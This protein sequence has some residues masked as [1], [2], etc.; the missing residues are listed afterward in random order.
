MT[1]ALVLAEFVFLC[2]PCGF[3]WHGSLWY[4]GL[5]R[6]GR[7]LP[8]FA[9]DGAADGDAPAPSAP[10]RAESV[11]LAPAPVPVTVFAPAEAEI[12]LP[13][14]TPAA[15]AP[16]DVGVLL[17]PG[18]GL[19]LDDVGEGD[20]LLG[21]T[22]GVG[23]P[24]IIVGPLDGCFRWYGDNVLVQDRGLRDGLGLVE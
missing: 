1:S 5:L 15:G 2:L 3:V 22:V 18:F 4:F 13:T 19:V 10:W 7:L 23:V 9:W 8:D 11:V 14:P 6:D 17:P 21:V 20:V 12:P 16:L 24:D